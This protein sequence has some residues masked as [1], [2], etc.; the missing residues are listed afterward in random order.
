MGF[1]F[2]FK[3]SLSQSMNFSI[4]FYLSVLSRRGSQRVAG[5]R[6]GS[7]PPPFRHLYTLIR[8]LQS[9]FFLQSEQSQLSQSFLIG[10][11]FSVLLLVLPE[12]RC[13]IL[14]PDVYRQLSQL[15]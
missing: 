10:L 11:Y 15:S 3:L 12:I 2:L 7:H 5:W 14:F 1:A 13:N 9:N 4:L 8:S 6:S